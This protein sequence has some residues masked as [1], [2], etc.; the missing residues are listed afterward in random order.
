MIDLLPVGSIVI[1]HGGHK[2][3]MIYGRLQRQEG[4]ENMGLYRML[5]SGR[6][7]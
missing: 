2:R 4:I 1:P 3:V 7:Y 5:I 6:T